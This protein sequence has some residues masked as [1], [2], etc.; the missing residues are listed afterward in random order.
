MDLKVDLAQYEILLRLERRGVLL[1]L[2]KFSLLLIN[3]IASTYHD[4]IQV[5][6]DVSYDKC[7][8]LLYYT[9]IISLFPI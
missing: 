4:R 5:L 9:K 2:D 8:T 7:A 3:R 1:L 6:F